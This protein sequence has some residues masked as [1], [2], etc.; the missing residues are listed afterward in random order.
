MDYKEIK[1][2]K[3]YRSN[4]FDKEIR[5]KAKKQLEQKEV[6]QTKN[7]LR[8]KIKS[9][10]DVC[11]RNKSGKGDRQ[12]FNGNGLKFDYMANDRPVN[13]VLKR[14]DKQQINEQI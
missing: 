13:K 8:K 2:N 6:E 11:R 7:N 12:I 9:L 1:S 3:Y 10:E 14:M 4:R 5:E